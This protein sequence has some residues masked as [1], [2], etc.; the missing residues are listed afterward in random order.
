MESPL[1]APYKVIF[2]DGDV[3]IEMGHISIHHALTFKRLQSLISQKLGMSPNQIST[4]LVCRKSNQKR[5]KIPITETTS[6]SQILIHNS[7]LDS[8]F[9]VTIK[10]PKRDRRSKPQRIEEGALPSKISPEKT[11]LRRNPDSGKPNPGNGL[12]FTGGYPSPESYFANGNYGID[13]RGLFSTVKERTSTVCE[14][15]RE[16]K[17]RPV[18]FH[19]CVYDAVTVGFRGPSPAGPIGRPRKGHVEAAA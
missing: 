13:G 14:L 10:K 6:F 7:N 2:F 4:S 8:F 16:S 3:D 18:P 5:L 9:L 1:S 11:L 15:C 17:E 12:Q 19:L